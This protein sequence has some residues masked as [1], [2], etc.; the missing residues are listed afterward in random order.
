V[1]SAEAKDHKM[2][3]LSQPADTDTTVLSGTAAALS[4][5]HSALS[6]LTRFA[7]LRPVAA[8]SLAVLAVLVLLAVAAPVVAPYDPIDPSA[9]KSTE[10]PSRQHLFG[11]DNLGRDVFSRTIWGAR[12]SLTVGAMS[13]ALALAIG[14]TAGMLSA[15][16]GGVADLTLMRVV[17]IV[18]SLPTLILALVIVAVLGPSVTNVILAVAIGYWPVVARVVRSSVLSLKTLT[19]VEAARTV[20]A[21]HARIL[22][23]HLLPNVAP[24][25]LVYAATVLGGA[26]L[27]EGG[28]SFLGVG[29][30]PPQPS[31]G[32]DI[33]GTGRTLMISA[34]WL[35]LFPALALS[36]TVL[37]VNLLADGL[38]DHLDPRLR[39]GR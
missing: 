26:I 32:Q 37:S 3:R 36:L 27:A 15:Y 5:Q 8:V 28:L 17:D 20:G 19:Y 31:W 1:L 23:R 12:T 16:W 2:T 29:T 38:R 30:P 39:M 7:R 35:V 33:S 25:I 9:G 21:S 13:V 4:T 18:M 34:P 14:C 11:T 24:V 6:T 10:A 22:L